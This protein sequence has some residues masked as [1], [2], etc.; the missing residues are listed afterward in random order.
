M[1]SSVEYILYYLASCIAVVFVLVPHE[2]AHGLVANWNGDPTAKINGRL[3]LNPLKH[4]EPLGYLMCVL[5][6]FGW[7]KPVP[8]NSAN[9]KNYKVG[10][11][12]TSIAGISANIILAFLFCPLMLLC[13]KYLS[14]NNYGTYFVILLF[15]FIFSYNLC[16]AIYNL[17]P[18][19]PL[20]GFK[21]LESVTKPYN[22]VTYFL[23]K[24]GQ[25]IL[26]AL[27]A[28]SFICRIASNYWP[29]FSDLNIL[30]Y[31]MTFA[32]EYIGWPIRTFWEL[33]I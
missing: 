26:L 32:T 25:T 21:V 2:F 30:G 16:I 20:D 18:L 19:Y 23:G 22:R 15:N 17:L 4:F 29:V 24:Y 5:V 33:F 13:E 27:I 3:S 10:L 8:V 6:G 9:F 11:F 31:V 7:A 28:E 1:V 12:T 14:Y